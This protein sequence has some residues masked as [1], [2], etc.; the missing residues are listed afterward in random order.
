MVW[1]GLPS[2]IVL[3]ALKLFLVRYHRSNRDDPH[4]YLSALVLALL[5]VAYLIAFGARQVVHG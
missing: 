5:G 3:I 1:I 4:D 2:V